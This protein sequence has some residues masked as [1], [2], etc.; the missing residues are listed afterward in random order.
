MRSKFEETNWSRLALTPA[1]QNV[2]CEAVERAAVNPLFE[3]LY[4]QGVPRVSR[5]RELIAD[6]RRIALASADPGNSGRAEN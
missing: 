6:Y 3:R 5:R 2:G 1:E 4:F